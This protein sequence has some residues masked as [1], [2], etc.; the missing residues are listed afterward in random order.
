MSPRTMCFVG[1]VAVLLLSVPLIAQF[2]HPMKGSW[3]GEWWVK[4]GDENRVLIEFDWDGKN[5]T[6]MLNPGTDNATLQKVSLQ[7][8]P[9][10]NVSKAKDP[11]LLHF[12]A[13]VKD[14]SGKAT[15]YVVDGKLQNLGAYSR[16][17]TGTWTV[18]NQKGEFKI[19]RN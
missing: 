7:T 5:L 19:V 2:G 17:V 10:D 8:P 16:F 9:V 11:W 15:H 3:S 1:I 14:T 6:G 13:D 4:K 12:E 18:G